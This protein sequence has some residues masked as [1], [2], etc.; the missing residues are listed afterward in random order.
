MASI[1]PRHGHRRQVAT[2]PAATPRGPRPTW[3]TA[4]GGGISTFDLGRLP[5]VASQ[6]RGFP[7]V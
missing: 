2:R 6:V 3:P 4:V 7:D 1:H 5:S